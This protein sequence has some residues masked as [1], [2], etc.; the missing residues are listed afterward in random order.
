MADPTE[1]FRANLAALQR[2]RRALEPQGTQVTYHLHGWSITRSADPGRPSWWSARN[3]QTGAA[4]PGDKPTLGAMARAIRNRYKDTTVEMGAD[5]LYAVAQSCGM[6][7][8]RQE[9]IEHFA[10]ALTPEGFYKFPSN[11]GKPHADKSP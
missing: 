1:Q 2:R 7:G 9:I 10:F 5:A 4:L 8:T 6:Q 3:I 11:K